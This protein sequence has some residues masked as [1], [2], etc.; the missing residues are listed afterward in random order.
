MSGKLKGR[1]LNWRIWNGSVK[2][3]ITMVKHH[4]GYLG[5]EQTK[6]NTPPP[7]PQ[8]CHRLFLNVYG[9]N[10]PRL[11]GT[12]LVTHCQSVINHY[13][14]SFKIQ[15][16]CSHSMVLIN[17]LG[18]GSWLHHCLGRAAFVQLEAVHCPRSWECGTT[19]A[20]IHLLSLGFWTSIPKCYKSIFLSLQKTN[21]RI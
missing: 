1:H 6:D 4:C 18:S 10:I 7:T 14:P 5:W 19:P 3:D 9:G 15:C 21:L 17:N 2:I 8:A 12:V 13:M 20:E 16:P 11:K